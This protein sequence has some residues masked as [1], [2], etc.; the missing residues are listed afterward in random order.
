MNSGQEDFAV[1]RQSSGESKQITE[2]RDSTV[3]MIG[4]FLPSK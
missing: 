2:G 4:Y 1:P 3:V